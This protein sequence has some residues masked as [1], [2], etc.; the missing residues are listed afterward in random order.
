[1]NLAIADD[2]R[3]DV[4]DAAIVN[5]SLLRCPLSQPPSEASHNERHKL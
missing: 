3:E 5:K 2:Q 1:M 4:R